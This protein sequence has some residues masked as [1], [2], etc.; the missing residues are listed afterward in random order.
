[1]MLFCMCVLFGGEGKLCEVIITFLKS[2]YVTTA[3]CV[4]IFPMLLG[5]L[6]LNICQA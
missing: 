2:L 4:R 1:M 3:S 6:I 5:K